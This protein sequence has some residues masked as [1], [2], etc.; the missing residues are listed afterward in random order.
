MTG[1]LVILSPEELAALVK[2]AVS[3]AL[4]E[5]QPAQAAPAS[6]L[7]PKK[8]YTVAKF[9]ALVGSNEKAIYDRVKDGSLPHFRAG[10]QKGIRIPETALDVWRTWQ[11]VN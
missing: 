2:S 1:P 9:A 11:A 3:E 8:F 6:T 10:R 4:A 5:H 7:D